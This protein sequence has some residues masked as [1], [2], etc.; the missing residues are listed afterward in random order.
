MSEQL[1]NLYTTTLADDYT[2][3]DGEL[4]VVSPGSFT[5]GTFSLTILN[6]TTGAVLLNFRVASVAG[7]VFTGQSEGRDG[8]L[9]AND[10]NAPAGSIVVGSM[11]TVDSVEQLFADHGALLMYSAAANLTVLN[12]GLGFMP[13]AGGGPAFD[14][15]TVF[16][17]PSPTAFIAQN[18]VVALGLPAGAGN[19]VTVTLRVNGVS[20]PLAVTI[21]GATAVAASDTVDQV[22]VNVGDIIDFMLTATGVFS[23]AN[24]LTFQTSINTGG[25]SSGGGGGGSGAFFQTLTPPVPGDFTQI[26]F[27]TGGCTT[28]QVNNTNSIT[29]VQNDPAQA[30]EIAG[31]TKAPINALFTI[32]MGFTIAANAGNANG[33]VTGGLWLN[34]GSALNIVFMLNSA[35][36]FEISFYN[37]FQGSFNANLFANPIAPMPLGPLVWLQIQ[38]TASDRI[39]SFSSDGENFFEMFSESV[40]AHFTTA[41][42]GMFVECRMVPGLPGVGSLTC[43]SFAESTP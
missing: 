19:S 34:D 39:F 38:E 10:A 23:G 43:Y 35:Q 42:Y 22:Q 7:S 37:N 4:T 16:T 2:A 29:L 14:S 18:L 24:V 8:T 40:T 3:G 25:A 15:E 9:G 20:T 1:F 21:A 13:V 41:Q 30:L 17:F 36:A 12:A 31:L 28:T 26:N 33:G 6:A 11:L 32:K 5:E 27:N